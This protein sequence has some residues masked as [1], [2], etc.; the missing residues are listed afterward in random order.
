MKYCYNCNKITPGEPLFCNYCGRSYNVKLCPRRH[1]NPRAAEACSQCGSRDLSTPQP[2]VPLWV[3]LVEFAVSLVPGV[4]L[5]VISIAAVVFVINAV[6]QRPD[7]LFALLMLFVALGI[8]WWVWSQLPQ[9]FRTAIYKV[10]KRRRD[11][12]GEKRER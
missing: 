6:A 1:V 8:L 10:L 11:S 12:G 7:L 5:S 3:P 2:R 4:F 9:W